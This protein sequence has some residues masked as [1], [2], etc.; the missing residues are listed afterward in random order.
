L[1]IRA[2]FTILV[3][4]SLFFLAFD[5]DQRQNESLLH[6][7]SKKKVQVMTQLIRSSVLRSLGFGVAL[8]LVACISGC[9][10]GAGASVSGTVLVDGKPA[11]KGSVRFVPDKSKGNT[12][13]QEPTGTIG[14][15]GK[16]TL[17]APKGWYKATV[18]SS[19]TPDSTK[20]NATKAYVAAKY[21]NPDT[22]G[23]SVEVVGSPAAGAYDLKVTEK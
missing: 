3:F 13:G 12:F 22:S 18:V 2:F 9:G 11:T 17:K 21:G 19:E 1:V 5:E 23:L 4:S 14:A 16:Y 10:D 20:P 6:V 7:I 15:D 8:T